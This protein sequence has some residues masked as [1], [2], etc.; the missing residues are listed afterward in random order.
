MEHVVWT[1]NLI[2]AWK[3]LTSHV[4]LVKACLGVGWE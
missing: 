4:Y 1:S 2:K 3:K